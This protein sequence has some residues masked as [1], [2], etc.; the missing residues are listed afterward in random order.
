MCGGSCVT[1][2]NFPIK[3]TG[4]V[5]YDELSNCCLIMNVTYSFDANVAKLLLRTSDLYDLTTC[6]CTREIDKVN[7]RGF[8]AKEM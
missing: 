1:L 6:N 5:L 7:D 4:S 8:G 2:S 3:H